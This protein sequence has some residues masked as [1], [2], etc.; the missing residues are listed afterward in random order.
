MDRNDRGTYIRNM[1]YAAMAGQSGC[2]SSALVVG[3]LLLGLWLDSMLGTEPILALVF[4][5]L[6]VPI[7]LVVMVYMVLGAARR[8]TPPQTPQTQPRSITDE[9]E[10]R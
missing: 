8:I 4:I 1:S 10:D 7:S 5:I 2:A 6:S 9:D 3:A